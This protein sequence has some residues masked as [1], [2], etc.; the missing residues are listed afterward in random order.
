MVTYKLTCI[1][2]FEIS[3]YHWD[4]QISNPDVGPLFI[5]LLM[6]SAISHVEKNNKQTTD[7]SFMTM[8]TLRLRRRK[9]T[10]I[11]CRKVNLM[12]LWKMIQRLPTHRE[13]I[14]GK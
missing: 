10:C 6:I 8:M 4:R 1:H 14:L 2:R 12:I 7:R 13:I 3:S 5:D 9:M 11:C